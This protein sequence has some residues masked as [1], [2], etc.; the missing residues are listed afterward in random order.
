MLALSPRG[1]IVAQSGMKPIVN[2]EGTP[3]KVVG[4][5]SP[6]DYDRLAANARAVMPRLPFPKGVYRFHTHEEADEWI[7]QHIL[8]A[9]T[10]E[11]RAPRNK[12]T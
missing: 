9:A 5:R 1:A 10:N 7:N 3:G 11:G 6:V 12:T 2:L 4:R 8:Q